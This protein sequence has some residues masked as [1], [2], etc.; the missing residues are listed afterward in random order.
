M[1]Q[2]LRRSLLAT[3]FLHKNRSKKA[4]ETLKTIST[5]LHI[6]NKSEKS[7][8][9]YDMLVASYLPLCYNLIRIN[10]EREKMLSAIYPVPASEVRLPFYLL[11]IGR[12][13][14]EFHVKRDKGLTSHQ[15]L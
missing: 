11:G 6:K 8:G 14:P 3:A 10:W 12:T 13:S 9:G 7:K 15:F 2:N 4:D 5:P 1:T